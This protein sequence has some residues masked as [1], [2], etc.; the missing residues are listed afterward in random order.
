MKSRGGQ[1]DQGTPADLA[2][3]TQTGAK[4]LSACGPIVVLAGGVGAARFLRGLVRA[5]PEAEITILGNTGDDQKFYGVHVAP[6]IDI[7]TYT[8]AGCID[9][10]R[11][12]G[13]ADDSFTML[14]ILEALGHETWFRLGDRDFSFCLHR[15]LEMRQGKTLAEAIDTIRCHFQLRPRLLP[16]SNDP[17]PSMIELNDG[18]L[19]HFQEYLVRE[20]AP[21]NIR[22]IDLHAAANAKPADGVVQALTDAGLI[23][24]CPSNPLVSIG[25]ILAI[26]EIR[27]ALGASRAPKVAISPI[28]GGAPVKGPAAQMLR[29]A[30]IEVSARGVANHYRDLIDG[31]VIDQVDTAQVADIKALGLATIAVDTLMR[32]EIVSTKLAAT[33]LALAQ[34]LQ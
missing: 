31:F 1:L 8:L 17:C 12:Y 13:I 24:F 3:C 33:A 22:R 21:K 10:V 28:I 29:A 7:V 25:P 4:S 27:N 2:R 34:E 5:T 23:L 15:T 19:L 14:Q 26:P 30:G 11:G 16:M 32:N 18:R 20:R 6:D 9:S